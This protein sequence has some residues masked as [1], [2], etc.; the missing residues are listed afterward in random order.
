MPLYLRYFYVIHLKASQILF[1]TREFPLLPK[2]VCKLCCI[3]K[4][5]VDSDYSSPRT[6]ADIGVG[7]GGLTSTVAEHHPEIGQEVGEGG[8]I[9]P[10]VPVVLHP[11]SPQTENPNIGPLA[12]EVSFFFL[13]LFVLFEC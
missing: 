10:P 2:V 12:D 11:L 9:S 8:V 13:C 4:D 3:V 1:S 6:P 7:L 5:G